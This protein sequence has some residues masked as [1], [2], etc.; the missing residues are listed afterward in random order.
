MACSPAPTAAEGIEGKRTFTYGNNLPN[1]QTDHAI[2][3]AGSLNFGNQQI[4]LAGK[5]HVL[6]GCAGMAA[7]TSRPLKSS[8]I[9]L[10]NNIGKGSCHQAFVE[11]YLVAVPAPR[12]QKKVWKTSIIN[13]ISIATIFC[14]V[15]GMPSICD[16][17]CS[18][19]ANR[20]GQA[21]V[22]GCGP[23]MGR[24]WTN[25]IKMNNLPRCMNTGICPACRDYRM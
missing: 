3:K 11:A 1:Q 15:T 22:K 8:K 18:S 5:A 14:V 12:C 19:D 4:P 20:L 16:F 9:M 2:K 6:N 25:G 21:A 23:S 13:S 7:A 10:A 17:G 24:D